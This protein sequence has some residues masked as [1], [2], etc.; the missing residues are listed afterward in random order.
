MKLEDYAVIGDTHTVALVGRNGSIDWLCLPRFDSAA[1][2]AA[3]LGG[4]EHGRF[5]IR[6]CGPWRSERRYRGDSLVLE[7]TFHTVDGTARLVDTMPIRDEHPSVVRVL[8]AISGAVRMRVE[9]VV[10]FEYGSAVPWV[11][12]LDGRLQAL[13]GPEALLLATPAPMRGE[14]LSTVAEVTIRAGERL[15]FVLTWHRSHEPPPESIDPCEAVE[16]SERWWRAWSSRH[17]QGGPHRDA[18][19]RSLLT[20]KALTFAPT[21]GIVAAGTTSLPERLG[22]ERNWDYRYCWLRDA[23]LTLRALVGAGYIEE[24][25]AWRDWLLRAVAGDPG[26]MQTV[27]GPAGER[28]LDEL[29]VDWLPGYEGSRPVRIGNRAARQFQLDVYGE[30]L[31]TLHRARSLGLPSDKHSWSLQSLVGEWL[32]SKWK[33]PDNGLWEVRG[34]R[35]HFVHSKVMAW[36]ALDRLVKAIEQYGRAGPLDRWRRVRAEIH[37][38]VCRRG[39]D[40]DL[41]SFT[42]SYGSKSLDASLLLVPVV[43][44]LPPGD[45]RIQGTIAA[46]ER[47]L[48]R[49]GFV[50]RYATTEGENVDGLRGRDGAFLACSFWLVDALAL[51]GRDREAR[52]LFT[53]LVGVANDVGLLSEEYDLDQRRFVG[54]FPQAFSHVALVNAGLNLAE[55]DVASDASPSLPRDGADELSDRGRKHEDTERP[56]KQAGVDAP[57]EVRSHQAPG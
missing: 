31:D 1:C 9:L 29:T 12:R 56:P 4:P 38:E 45:P 7:T 50:L 49:D 30:V 22:G 57:A 53:Q 41:G 54:N 19:T 27:Y 40:P 46:V 2:F 42:Q 13:A 16:T 8:E 14:G 20:L 36:A 25:S 3:L 43:G 6:P 48:V 21:G 24:A 11:R 34:T 52:A 47:H 44:F 32:E 51:S 39:F 55:P 15:P 37:D 35:R 5:A 28:R 23:S 18:I 10:R 26:Q 33:T 17:R